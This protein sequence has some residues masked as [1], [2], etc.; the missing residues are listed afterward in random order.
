LADRSADG[1]NPA[2]LRSAR[3]NIQDFLNDYGDHP[4]AE[5]VWSY[6]DELELLEYERRMERRAL[7]E[8]SPVERAYVGILA[9]SPYDHEQTIDKLRAFIAVFQSVYVVSEESAKPS[10]FTSSPVETCV[11]L[12]R[13]R[14]KK[15]EQ[16]VD[17]INEVQTQI[18]RRR[19]DEAANLESKNPQ[20]AEEIRRGI[21]ELY[22][23]Y[24]WAKELVEEAESRLE[25]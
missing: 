13:R 7:S 3:K 10:R 16:D 12:A 23:D 21:I 5:Q 14:L 20:H 18:L 11:E 15:L 17:E 9:T 8:L 22:K 6:Q 4:L 24:R 1:Y 25:E 2:S 19:L